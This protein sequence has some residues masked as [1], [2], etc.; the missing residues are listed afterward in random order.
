MSERIT[1]NAILSERSNDARCWR[2]TRKIAEV[3]LLGG[4]IA[5]VCS[6]CK[7]RNVVVAS[8]SRVPEPA[9]VIAP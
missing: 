9:T 5:V 1:Q 7:A 8:G 4:S 3:L 2:C 6:R